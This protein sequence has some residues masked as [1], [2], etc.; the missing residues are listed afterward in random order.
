[1]DVAR[2]DV[3]LVD[4]DP[5]VGR[6][7]AKRQPAVVV[8]NDV[9]HRLAPTTIVTA[10]TAYS[11]KNAAFPFC[12]AAARG[13]GGLSKRSLVNCAHIRPIDNARIKRRLGALSA[14]TL[15]EVDLALRISLALS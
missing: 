3:V 14:E 7:I 6:E 12:V 2:G 4:F 11:D 10:I 13:E 1:M 8:Q 5:A 15:A 9:G